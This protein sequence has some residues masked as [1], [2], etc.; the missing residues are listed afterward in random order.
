MVAV[1]GR[2]LAAGSRAESTR[3][4]AQR[5][6]LVSG[7][8][9]KLVPQQRTSGGDEQSM[10]PSGLLEDDARAQCRGLD[11]RGT[12]MSRGNLRPFGSGQSP[13]LTPLRRA[14]SRPAP[15]NDREC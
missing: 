2:A 4:R 1:S 13:R 11:I 12:T 15:N 7:R 3:C 6:D 14:G 9:W 5:D 8:G 10:A